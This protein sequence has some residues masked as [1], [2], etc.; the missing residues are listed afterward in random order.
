MI[1]L[2]RRRALGY[3]SPFALHCASITPWFPTTLPFGPH[4]LVIRL[5]HRHH[6]LIVQPALDH[7][8]HH[9]VQRIAQRAAVQGQHGRPCA[10]HIFNFRDASHSEA[11][12]MQIQK[13]GREE[14]GEGANKKH[15]ANRRR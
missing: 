2:P 11:S 5:C 10:E 4:I 9:L 1:A 12:E 6:L 3:G 15:A 13:Y 14:G 8:L 7:L